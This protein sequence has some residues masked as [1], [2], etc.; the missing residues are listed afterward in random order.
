MSDCEIGKLKI[1]KVRSDGA[2]HRKLR[3]I[4]KRGVDQD[5]EGG[6]GEAQGNHDYLGTLSKKTRPSVME[7]SP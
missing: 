5:P 2:G 4:G 1:H 6:G 3:P 7:V